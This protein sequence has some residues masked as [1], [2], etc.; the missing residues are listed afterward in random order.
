MK[1]DYIANINGHED[2][3]VRLYDFNKA[4][5]IKFRDIVKQS[6]ITN[7]T[8]LELAS[9]DFIESRNCKLIL[10]I[11]EEDFGILEFRKRNFYCDM[12]T[13]GYIKMLA[14]LEP[15]CHKETKGY[16]YLYD[17]DNPTDFLFSPA[18]SW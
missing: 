2:N 1:L 17:I 14:L 15:F 11:T 7:K 13:E 4:E 8:T 5:A 3:V 10:R 12:T 6:I 9:L 16:Q 18:G